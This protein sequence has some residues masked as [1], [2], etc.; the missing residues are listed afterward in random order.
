MSK[1]LSNTLIRCSE[2]KY[3]NNNSSRANL[4][5]TLL[6]IDMK[7]GTIR[8]QLPLKK[9]MEHFSRKRNKLPFDS[10]IRANYELDASSFENT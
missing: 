2:Y 7:E 1:Y 6:V 8:Y 9:G 3:E 4:R 5:A 10:I